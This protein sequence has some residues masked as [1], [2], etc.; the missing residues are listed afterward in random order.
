MVVENPSG[1]AEGGASGTIQQQGHHRIADRWI[2][3]CSGG[4][5]PILS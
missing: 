2:S 5:A 1:G 3:A 4:G